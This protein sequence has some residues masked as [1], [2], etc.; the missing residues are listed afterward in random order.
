M[1]KDLWK[2]RFILGKFLDIKKS[3]GKTE[4]HFD[5]SSIVLILES[6]KKKRPLLYPEQ[7]ILISPR[8]LLHPEANREDPIKYIYI[9]ISLWNLCIFFSLQEAVHITE[10]TIS[11]NYCIYSYIAAILL[12]DQNQVLVSKTLLLRDWKKSI[13]LK[14]IIK[15]KKR[16]CSRI[17][18]FR[19]HSNQIIIF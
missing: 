11:D 6:F 2:Y 5:T 17:N 1:L 10:S 8:S 19:V 9:Y 12:I 16:I 15:N 7:C 14:H 18:S 13:N 4:K 3:N